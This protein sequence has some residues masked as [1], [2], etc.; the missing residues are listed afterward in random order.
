MKYCQKCGNEL[1][2]EAILCPKCGCSVVANTN[3]SQK[4]QKAKT[5]NQGAIMIIVGIAIIV[6]SV[7]LY[8][9]CV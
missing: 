1:L 4:E 6:V 9:M 5:Q 2:D 8:N 7:L 3:N